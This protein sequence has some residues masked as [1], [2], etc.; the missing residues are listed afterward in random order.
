[1]GDGVKRLETFSCVPRHQGRGFPQHIG[2]LQ[3]CLKISLRSASCI[4][5]TDW[6]PAWQAWLKSKGCLPQEKVQTK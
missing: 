6:K 2:V 3:P 1:M 5:A 4:G